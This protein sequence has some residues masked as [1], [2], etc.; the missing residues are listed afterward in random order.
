MV[1]GLIQNDYVPSIAYSL[2]F[3]R[4]Q[5]LIDPKADHWNLALWNLSWIILPKSRCNW[6]PIP[7]PPPP[8]KER[9]WFWLSKE[10]RYSG[11]YLNQAHAPP[12]PPQIIVDTGS[13][14]NLLSSQLFFL[15][16]L[17]LLHSGGAIQT[18]VAVA[19]VVE[20]GLQNIQH[21]GHLS[22]DEHPVAAHLQLTQQHIQR[23]QLAWQQNP[24]LPVLM[25]I[26]P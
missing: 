12:L 3:A 24:A 2:P 16:D 17:S 6:V 5:P 9:L 23:L 10:R 14:P 20:E 1:N 18:E 7:P 15:T 25:S 8:P 4:H 13:W 19:M 21:L 22:E 26:L 11:A